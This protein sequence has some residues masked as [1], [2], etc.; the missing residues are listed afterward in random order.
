[1]QSIQKHGLGI[2]TWS[3]LCSGLLTGKYNESIP[4]NS[5]LSIDRLQWLKKALID[6]PQG[7]ARILSTKQLLKIAEELNV[8]LS[9]LAIAWC[10]KN[11]NVNSVILG[12]RTPE[13]LKENLRAPEIIDILN[14]E[15]LKKID[16]H[17]KPSALF[18]KHKELSTADWKNYYD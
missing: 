17:I 18:Q 2:T 6:S 8:S 4:K 9:T 3:P 1:L 10:L 5:R 12:A 16:S 14:K 7:Q 11:K 15:I 13:Q